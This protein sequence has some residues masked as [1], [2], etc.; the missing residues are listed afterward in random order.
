MGGSSV[1]DDE[2]GDLMADG[3]LR[4]YGVLVTGGGTGIGRAC[5]EALAAGLSADEAGKGEGDGGGG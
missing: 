2:G 5:A 1:G 3:D 4:G